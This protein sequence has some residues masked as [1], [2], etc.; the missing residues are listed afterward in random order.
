MAQKAVRSEL[1]IKGSC[2]CGS[3]SFDVGG[4][5][6]DVR[7][8]YCVTCRKLSGALFSVVANVP[9]NRFSLCKGGDALAVYESMPGKLRYY[10][11]SCFSPVFVKVNSEPDRVRIRLG[12]L[13]SEPEVNITAHM[14]TSEK[15]AWYEISDGLP[16]FSHEFTE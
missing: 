1:V 12:L 4:Q 3:V 9:G 15:P 8:C 5:L 14:W 6:G 7:F 10:C 13:D 11:S 16:Q 2:H